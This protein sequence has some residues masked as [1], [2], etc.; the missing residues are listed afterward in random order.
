MTLIE[1]DILVVGAGPAGSLAARESSKKG[2]DV[3]LIDKKAEIGTPKRCAEGI[4]TR[5]LKEAN[6]EVDSRWIARKIDA[7]RII[8]PNSKEL[9]LDNNVNK[10]PDTGYILERKVFDKHMAMDAIRNGTKVMLRTQAKTVERKDDYLIVKA[11]SMDEL[12][13]IHTKIVIAADGPES[14]IGRQLGLKSNTDMKDMAS[15]VQYEMV[16]IDKDNPNQIDIFIGSVAPAGYVWIFPKASDVANVG[17]GVLKT[18]TDDTALDI[19]N[20]FIKTHKET[21][22]AQSV[23][24]NVGGDPLGGILKERYDDNVMVVGDAA[25][26]VNPLTGDGIRGALLSGMYAGHVAADAVIRKDYSKNSLKEY[27]ELTEN[28]LNRTYSKFNRIKEF[29]LTLD[30]DALNGIVDELSK[31]DLDEISVKLLL[32]VILKASPKSILQIRKML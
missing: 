17:L 28:N 24:M 2:L 14:H 16:G 3:L 27:Y 12:I 5:T 22:N 25:G 30:D 9:I 8:A 23:E 20:G 11:V 32:K 4:I 10:L 21:Q 31:T 1:T 15:C 29:M 6:I 26:F 19:L 18:Y 7:I 13:E